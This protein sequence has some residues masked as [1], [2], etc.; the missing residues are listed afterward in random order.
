MTRLI[1]SNEEMDDIMNMVKSLGDAGL[2]LKDVSKT[3]KN[4][5]K[6][7]KDGFLSSLLGTVDASLLRNLLTG[8]RVIL[9]GEGVIVTSWGRVTITE[10]Q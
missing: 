6:E 5:A 7:Q 3:I 4:K 10:D 1:I 8:K 9:D 2:L